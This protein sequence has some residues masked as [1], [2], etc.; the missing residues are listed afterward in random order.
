M[1]ILFSLSF[2]FQALR[3]LI[4]KTSIQSPLRWISSRADDSHR[5]D[6]PY[7]FVENK[8]PAVATFL[9]T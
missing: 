9:F 7:R 8:K 4:N 5:V 6:F 2:A 3:Q 1:E